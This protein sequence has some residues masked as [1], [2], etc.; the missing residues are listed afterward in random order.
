MSK[1]QTLHE[2]VQTLIATSLTVDRA[3][4][5]NRITPLEWA[6]IALKSIAFWRTIRSIPELRAEILNLTPASRFE[7]AEYIRSELDLRNDRLEHTIEQLLQI[8]LDL[9]TLLTSL[10]SKS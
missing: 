2:A 1:N 8:L 7:L 9:S 5:D 3:L 4:D 6:Q 10:K